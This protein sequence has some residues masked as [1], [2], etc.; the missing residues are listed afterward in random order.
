MKNTDTYATPEE[1]QKYLEWSKKQLVDPFDQWL[2]KELDRI[3]P[4]LYEQGNDNGQHFAM[5]KLIREMKAELDLLKESKKYGLDYFAAKAM[6][7]LLSNNNFS[8]NAGTVA[9]DA[10]LI[11]EQMIKAGA[12]K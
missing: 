6:Q 8:G 1:M 2:A 9:K 3:D 10:Y 5:I 4:Y 12:E 11:A 7:G